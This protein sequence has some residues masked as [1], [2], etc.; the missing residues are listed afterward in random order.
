MYFCIF[1]CNIFSHFPT[2]HEPFITLRDKIDFDFPDILPLPQIPIIENENVRYV[3]I[4]E[5]YLSEAISIGNHIKNG[6]ITDH[7]IYLP[8]NKLPQDL[9]IFRK[10]GSGKTY[11]LAR[12]IYQLSLKAPNVGILVLNL[13]KE[14]QELYYKNIKTIKYSDDEFHIPYYLE[15][16]HKEKPLQETATYICVSLGLKNVYEKIIYHSEIGFVKN[17]GKLPMWFI[18]LLRGVERF[19]E[20]HPYGSESQAN[21]LQALRNRI[22]VFKNTKIQS[23]LKLTGILPKWFSEWLD[24]KNIFLDV[25][26]CEKFSKM[27]II[28]AILQLIRIVTKDSEIEELKHLIVIDEAH[29]ILEKP[30][31]TN[32]DDAD[33]IMKEQMAKI[34]SKILKEYRSRGLGIIIADQWPNQ[35]FDDVASQPSIKVLFKLDYPNNLIFSEDPY[36]RKVLTQLQNQLALVNNGATGE[37][38]LIKSLIYKIE[39]K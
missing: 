9:E 2:K 10:S 39:K 5:E 11:F 23:V 24:G 25:S 1:S 20:K 17:N 33:F 31:T 14:S 35:L 34:F 27:L 16:P 32:S 15:L 12:F 38:Y 21:L 22:K 28:N 18:T 19:M 37:K 8:I 36:E 29:A 30:I 4:K 3:D 13:A 6:I 26:M 7:E